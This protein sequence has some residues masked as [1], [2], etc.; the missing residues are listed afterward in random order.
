MSV[1]TL[2]DS[3]FGGWG[4]EIKTQKIQGKYLLVKQPCNWGLAP[5]DFQDTPWKPQSIPW[6]VVI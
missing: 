2:F 6:W 5:S 3:N 4:M 1:E